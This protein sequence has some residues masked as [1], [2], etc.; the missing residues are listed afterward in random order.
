[1]A[2]HYDLHV[3]AQLAIDQVDVLRNGGLPSNL[4]DRLIDTIGQAN[5][6]EASDL[7][8]SVH[9]DFKPGNLMIS[10]HEVIGIDMEGYGWGSPLTDLG[11]FI[12]TTAVLRSTSRFG[13]VSADYRRLLCRE[14]LVAYRS[15]AE[16]DIQ[17]LPLQALKSI[18]FLF[19]YMTRHQNPLLWWLRGRPIMVQTISQ[20]LDHPLVE[21]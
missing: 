9:G 15:V 18:V 5:R 3:I 14:F 6:G 8:V 20:A 16:W 13:V 1:M 12:A 2:S 11:S 10:G 19:G 17:G 7:V 21:E 4:A